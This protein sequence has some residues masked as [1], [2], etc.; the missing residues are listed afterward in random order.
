MTARKVLRGHPHPDVVT[1]MVTQRV[2]RRDGRYYLIVP[3]HAAG[4]PRRYTVYLIP[5][6]PSQPVLV[7]GREL[8]IN[9]CKSVIRKHKAQEGDESELVIRHK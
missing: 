1:L 3:D 8:P 6:S 2:S 4:L 7:L 5:S 9:V